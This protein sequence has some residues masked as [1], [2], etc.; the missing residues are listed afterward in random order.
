MDDDTSKL[1]GAIVVALICGVA[2]YCWQ[3][4]HEDP[5]Q[6]PPLSEAE[7]EKLSKERF[8]QMIVTEKEIPSEGIGA[9]GSRKK[10][11]PK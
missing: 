11:P 2:S 8:E 5:G 6:S 4:L 1:V 7:E 9:F 10:P 3:K